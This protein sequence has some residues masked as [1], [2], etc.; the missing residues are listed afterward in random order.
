MGEQYLPHRVNEKIEQD[1]VYKA[2]GIV[3][4]TK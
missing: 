3:F 1:A 2:L 4:G